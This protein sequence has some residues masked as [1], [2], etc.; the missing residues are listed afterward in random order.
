MNNTARVRNRL[1]VG[2]LLLALA[3]PTSARAQGIIYGDSVPA[4]ATVDYDVVLIGQNVSLDGTVN[5]N[6]FI[7]GNQVTIN[8]TVDGSVVLIGQNAVIRGSV[9][10][11]VYASALTLELAPGAELARELYVATVSLVTQPGSGIGRDLFAVS[12][13]AGLGGEIGRAPHTAIGPIQLYN[14]LMTLLGFDELTIKLHIDFAAPPAAP[15]END[16]E[17]GRLPPRVHARRSLQQ[18]EPF[19]WNGWALERAREWVVLS[20]FG[21]LAF[22]LARPAL[23]SFG[24]PLEARPYRA[25]GIGM[26]ALVIAFNVFGVALLMAALIF[27]IGLGLNYLGLWQLSIALWIAAYAALALLLIALWFFIV[28]GTKIIVVFVLTEWLMLRAGQFA[29]WWKL[30]ALLAGLLAFV[31]LRSTPYVGWAF[32]VLVTAAGLG[33]AWLAYRSR[34]E[35]MLAPGTAPVSLRARTPVVARP[36]SGALRKG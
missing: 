36:K 35:H 29:A 21:L 12:L 26:L 32:G 34:G 10:G 5:G 18:P 3:F 28:Y 20:L 25:T 33:S 9:K 7:L 6:V 2:L 24:R 19:D 1:L 31:L 17:G 14:G 8:G 30:A 4:G 27:S 11:A 13:D 16:A 22:A 15:D 23:V